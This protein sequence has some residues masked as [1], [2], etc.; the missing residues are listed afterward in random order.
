MCDN[1]TYKIYLRI[2]V[3]TTPTFFFFLLAMWLH[4]KKLK[5]GTNDI[6]LNNDFFFFL[7]LELYLISVD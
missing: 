7:N 4:I 2:I 3:L 1:V 6:E 5:S